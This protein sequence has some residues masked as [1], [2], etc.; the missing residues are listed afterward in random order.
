MSNND[1]YRAY[2]FTVDTGTTG[3][4]HFVACSGLDVK[5][6]PIKYRE[7]GQNQIIRHIPGPVE[8]AAITLS[9]GMTSST[10]LWDWML[11]TIQ[12]DVQRKDISISML[13]DKTNEE[14]MSWTLLSAWPSEWQGA[15]LD[16]LSKE[17]AIEKL[18]LV[19]DGIKRERG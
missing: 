11:Q 5:V 16:S 12:G 8:Y 6:T 19:Y 17:I 3:K 13:N 9:Y 18:T 15:P 14:V 4:A 7:A 2:N 10:E 1:P